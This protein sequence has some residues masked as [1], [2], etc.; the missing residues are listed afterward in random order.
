MLYPLSYGRMAE[1]TG[2]EPADLV[3]GQLLSREP[4]S[5]T[6]AHLQTG[7][8]I[9][10][11]HA[12]NQ[13]PATLDLRTMIRADLAA[14]PPYVPGTSDP[15]ALKLSSNEVTGAPLPT[16]VEAM[17]QAAAGA[18]RYPDMGASTLINALARHLGVEPSNVALGCGS[19][20]LCQQLAQATSLP[21]NSIV[22]P[23][24]SFEAYPIF[25]RICGAEP[26]PVPLLIDG[27]LDL[28][29]ILSA[30]DDTTSLVFICTPNNPTGAVVT[31]DE[32]AEFMAQVPP[33]VT[34]ALD[35]AYFEFNRDPNAVNGQ[36]IWR[37]YPNVVCLRTFSK[38]YGLAGVRVGYAFG[39]AELITA[40][41]KVGVPFQVN[42]VAQ[43]GA[44]A[45]LKHADELLARVEDT[46]DVRDE[47]ADHIGAQHSQANFVWLPAPDPE[48]AP[49]IA[50]QLAAH[51]VLTRAFPEGLRIT[52]TNRDEAAEFLSAWDV[53]S[54]TQS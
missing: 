29:A 19:S 8:Q 25:A 2:F 5:A 31:A 53:V 1:M 46:V 6:L 41:N 45:S 39:N 26:R 54:S 47:V 16:A 30:I 23:W 7:L 15:E 48:W 17:T 3:K 38:A 11:N 52:V 9:T 40:M 43:A 49:R 36:E 37:E 22:F 4:Q 33:H 14:I 51:G 44:L 12:S 10:H 42:S 27:H 34:V 35:E 20:A 24:R 18:N 28:P 21:G 50:A 13:N 32:F